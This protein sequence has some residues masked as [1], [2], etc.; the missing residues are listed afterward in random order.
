MNMLTPVNT[1]TIHPV[2][3]KDTVFGILHPMAILPQD[4]KFYFSTEKRFFTCSRDWERLPTVDNENVV[5]CSIRILTCEVGDHHE[6]D[7]VMEYLPDG[8][9]LHRMWIKS[10]LGGTGH[11]ILSV[12]EPEELPDGF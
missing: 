7:L 10:W 11:R 5:E 3:F 4:D 1:I 2:M 12:E 6:V 9:F 8:G